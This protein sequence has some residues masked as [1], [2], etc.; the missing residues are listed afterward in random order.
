MRCQ[1]LYNL[2]AGSAALSY[3]SS[4]M[5]RLDFY[6]CRIG[7]LGNVNVGKDVSLHELRDLF[8]A[9]V[10]A[11]GAESD[12]RLG[13]PGEDARGVFSAREF[14]WWYNG[15]PDARHLPGAAYSFFWVKCGSQKSSC[16]VTG[17]QYFLYVDSMKLLSILYLNNRELIHFCRSSLAICQSSCQVSG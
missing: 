9:V 11:Y 12:R 14:V 13:V 6:S 7:F 5:S 15:H 10:L 17:A 4:K 1:Y 16:L 2:V 8:S 3:H